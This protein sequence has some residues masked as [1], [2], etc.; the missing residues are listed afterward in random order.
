[1]EE[2]KK[3]KGKKNTIKYSLEKKNLIVSKDRQCC[4]VS[5]LRRWTCKMI[6]RV[7][8]WHCSLYEVQQTRHSTVANHISP[9]LLFYSRH[10]RIRPIP[11]PPIRLRNFHRHQILLQSR[12]YRCSE[13]S[14]FA[15]GYFFTGTGKHCA[16]RSGTTTTSVSII[17]FLAGIFSL[18]GHST[19]VV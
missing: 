14:T 15:P 3:G 11:G 2:E 5:H 8:R 4:L 12:R 13:Q 6:G 19:S 17:R 10:P 18:E 9:L 1:M 16:R 7:M